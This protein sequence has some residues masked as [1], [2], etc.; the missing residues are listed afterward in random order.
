LKPVSVR[1]WQNFRGTGRLTT[2]ENQIQP[3]AP[4]QAQD[5][6]VVLPCF[7]KFSLDHVVRRVA[8]KRLWNGVT[9][10]GWFFNNVV[11]ESPKFFGIKPR[12]NGTV[13]IIPFPLLFDWQKA[14]VLWRIK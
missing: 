9:L 7:A 6:P 8:F 12:R 1:A 11:G 4:A 10:V 2:P 14:R 5:G 3:G 13:G